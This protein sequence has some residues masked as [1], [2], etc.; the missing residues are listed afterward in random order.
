MAQP[1]TGTGDASTAKDAEKLAALHAC[2]QL[3]ARGL[4]TET[5]LPTRTRGMK[6]P[7]HIASTGG[8]G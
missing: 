1:I 3:G 7:L 6:T 4:F 5:N 8:G 2:L